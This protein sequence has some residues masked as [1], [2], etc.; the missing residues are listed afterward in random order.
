M[1]GLFYPDSPSGLWVF[2]LVTMTLGGAAAWTTGRAVAKNWQR[3][4]LVPVYMLALA[5]AVRF[6]HYSLFAESFFSPHY[7][8]VDYA[9][10]VVAAGLGNK[11]MRA[12]QMVQQ[13]GWKFVSQGFFN[14][15]EKT[16][17]DSSRGS[18]S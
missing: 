5:A 8:L 16:P 13:Y 10:L 18:M 4:I 7:Y 17:M 12:R 14:W 15:R 9:V 11:H 1:G 6:L 2:L 3:P